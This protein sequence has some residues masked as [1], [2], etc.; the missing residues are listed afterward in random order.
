MAK[1]DKKD[2]KLNAKNDEKIDTKGAEKGS[3]LLFYIMVILFIIFVY[4]ALSHNI[5]VY[6]S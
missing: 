2:E 3:S 6:P 1:E 4:L 5:F